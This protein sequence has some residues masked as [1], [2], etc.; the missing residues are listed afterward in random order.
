M[1]GHVQEALLDTP[2]HA[3]YYRDL[4]LEAK[5]KAFKPG[6]ASS[7][8]EYSQYCRE[9]MYALLTLAELPSVETVEVLTEFLDDMDQPSNHENDSGYF[10]PLAWYSRGTL[11]NMIADGPENYFA[12]TAW[13]EWRDDIRR[14]H[15]TFR[16]KGSDVRYDFDGPVPEKSV[17]EDKPNPS[18]SGRAD[19][20]TEGEA[21]PSA[22]GEPGEAGAPKHYLV[23]AALALAAAI[24]VW[25]YSRRAG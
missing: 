13:R 18:R 15:R 12:I 8:P 19:A 16:F 2:G 23:I 21:R 3:H 14:G 22:P 10:A 17:R 11:H 1:Y 9:R 7:E 25:I 5:G 24:G 20:G 6:Q 4:I